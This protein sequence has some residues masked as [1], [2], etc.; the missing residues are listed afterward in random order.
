[1]RV[2][3]ENSP[4]G[5]KEQ[6][7]KSDPDRVYG[8]IKYTL[9]DYIIDD[10]LING[11]T[12][13][14][15]D[16]TPERL[17]FSFETSNQDRG[18]DQVLTY[19]DHANELDLGCRLVRNDDKVWEIHITPD[20]LPSPP[21]TT[22]GHHG[23]IARVS[24]GYNG[25]SQ[26]KGPKLAGWFDRPPTSNPPVTAAAAVVDDETNIVSVPHPR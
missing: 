14:S 17:I 8:P 12:I 9:A 20:P 26:P 2:V 16:R 10:K 5:S 22:S 11:C 4:T 15:V 13:T 23:D 7:A 24:I 21:K 25:S 6:L 3:G 1:M 18:W 19:K